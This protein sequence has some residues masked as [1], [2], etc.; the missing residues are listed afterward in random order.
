MDFQLFLLRHAALLW[1]LCRWTIRLLFPRSL[2]RA[3]LT[4]QHAAREHLATPLHPSNQKTLEWLFEERKR[5]AELGAGP[6]D[7][8]YFKTAR[9]FSAPQFRALYRQWLSDPTYTL[10]IAGSPLI[11]DALDRDHGRVECIELSRQYL[12]LSPLVN[13]A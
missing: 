13:L 8:R 2:W 1:V 9:N 7:D 3:R 6:A 10:S 12:H 11:A 4:Y 5:L